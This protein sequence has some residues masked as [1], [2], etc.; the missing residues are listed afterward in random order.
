[1]AHDDPV[2]D[3]AEPVFF[4]VGKP[5]IKACQIWHRRE[6]GNAADVRNRELIAIPLKVSER[7][8]DVKGLI[9]SA[10][11]KEG[12]LCAR[13]GPRVTSS[14]AIGKGCSNFR[15]INVWK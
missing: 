3:F 15:S 12:P 2:G 11:H 13:I 6:A 4:E 1:M 14:Q 8:E 10:W 9:G 7:H 5:G